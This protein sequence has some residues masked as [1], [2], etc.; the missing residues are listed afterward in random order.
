MKVMQEEIFGPVL[1]VKTYN[2]I[3]EATGLCERPRPAAGALL[4]RDQDEGG[5][6]AGGERHPRQAASPSMM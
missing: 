2:S 5:A 3:G 6:G 1:P 4:F